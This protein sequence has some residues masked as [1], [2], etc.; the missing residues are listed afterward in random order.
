MT[1][2]KFSVPSIG[3]SIGNL[4]WSKLVRVPL[5]DNMHYLPDMMIR[6]TLTKKKTSQKSINNLAKI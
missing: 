6:L 2:G 4:D 3:D 5:G 1:D